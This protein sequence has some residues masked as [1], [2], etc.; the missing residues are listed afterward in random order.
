M[1]KNEILKEIYGNEEKTQLLDKTV[2]IPAPQTMKELYN[3]L[4]EAG[5]KW[6]E[7][8][9]VTEFYTN[10]EKKGQVKSKKQHYLDRLMWLIF[11]KKLVILFLSEEV[12]QQIRTYFTCIIWMRVSI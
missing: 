4:H 1:D 12:L 6:R 2:E 11:L 5:K 8:N 10:G 3:T 9:T 7:A